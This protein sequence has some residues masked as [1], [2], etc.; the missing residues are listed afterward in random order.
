MTK[1][2]ELTR[3]QARELFDAGADVEWRGINTGSGSNFD[4]GS[5]R[6]RINTGTLVFAVHPNWHDSY[7]VEVE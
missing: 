2:K 1:Y 3:K 7:R 6:E 4:W 5:A